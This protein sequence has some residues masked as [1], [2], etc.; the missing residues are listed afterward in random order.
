[1]RTYQELITLILILKRIIY[2]IIYMQEAPDSL[3][4]TPSLKSRST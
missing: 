2:N 1:M 4:E 3:A